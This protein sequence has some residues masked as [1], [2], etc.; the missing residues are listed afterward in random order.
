[1]MYMKCV[2]DIINC[3]AYR[4]PTNSAATNTN[5]YENVHKQINQ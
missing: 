3:N 5:Q 4:I 2:A 1:M